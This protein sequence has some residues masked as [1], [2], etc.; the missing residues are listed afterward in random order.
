MKAW[1]GRFSAEPDADAADFGRSIEVDA[2]LALDDIAGS[3]AHVGGLRGA[4]LLSEAEAATIGDGLR[5]IEADVRAGTVAW[6]PALEDIHLNIEMALAARIGPWPASCT[7]AA[8]A[9]T[10]SP[11]TCGSG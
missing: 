9:T 5:A 10:R 8:R 3:L 7:P 2:E 11:R 1:G 4:G 6:D